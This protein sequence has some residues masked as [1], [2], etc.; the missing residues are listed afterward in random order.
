MDPAVH[1][2]DAQIFAAGFPIT[3]HLRPVVE[4]T[5]KTGIN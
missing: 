3:M 4:M 1:T 2:S 5:V